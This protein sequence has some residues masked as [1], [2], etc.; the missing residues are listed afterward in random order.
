ML[1]YYGPGIQA[2]SL[3]YLKNSQTACDADSAWFYV[4]PDD[5]EKNLAVTGGWRWPTGITFTTEEADELDEIA[6]NIPTFVNE[7]FT[8]FFTGTKDIND[9]TVWAQYLSDLETYNLSRILE[10]R[11]N[12]YDRYQAH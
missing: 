11:Q 6:Q 10:I 9:D 7:S 2:S 8:A 3:L 1:T 4:W 12:C 5:E